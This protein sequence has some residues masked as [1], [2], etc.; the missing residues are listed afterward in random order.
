MKDVPSIDITTCHS[1]V[2]QEDYSYIGLGDERA[3]KVYLE[4]Y[5]LE[6][7]ER[8][9]MKPALAMRFME[10]LNRL[11]TPQVEM[12]NLICI[13]RVRISNLGKLN[14]GYFISGK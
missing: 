4:L 12:Q 11:L 9:A 14:E 5:W 7:D 1:G 8:I 10:I 6:S 13:P 2:I 3:T